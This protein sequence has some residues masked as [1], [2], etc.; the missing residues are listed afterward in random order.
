MMN[1]GHWRRVE[2]KHVHEHRCY[3]TDSEGERWKLWAAAWQG[4]D[5]EFSEMLTQIGLM[6]DDPTWVAPAEG[7]EVETYLPES[8][9]RAEAERFARSRLS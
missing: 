5:G 1:F 4:Y 3:V 6:P 9:W 2:N 8:E 7:M